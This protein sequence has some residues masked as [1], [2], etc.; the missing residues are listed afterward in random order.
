MKM[1]HPRRSQPVIRLSILEPGLLELWQKQI[2]RFSTGACLN[3]KKIE[4]DDLWKNKCEVCVPL[5]FPA[6]QFHSHGN[7]LVELNWSAIS[8]YFKENL[9]LRFSFP[10]EQP[11]HYHNASWSVSIETVFLNIPLWTWYFY[12]VR[13]A[14]AKFSSWWRSN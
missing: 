1:Q 2:F 4:E 10:S 14:K 13:V 11:P 8:I 6:S 7:P 12:S 9:L 5:F 3:I